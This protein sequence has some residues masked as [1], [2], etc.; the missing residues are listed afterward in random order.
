LLRRAT[1]QLAKQST[2]APDVFAD[3]L[4][5]APIDDAGGLGAVV[6]ERRLDGSVESGV[7]NPDRPGASP[8]FTRRRRFT[9]PK[10]GWDGVGIT[11]GD[12]Y[13]RLRIDL[14]Y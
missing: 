5:A 6:L 3:I 7:S 4:D 9:S 8:A 13:H 1:S 12:P 10:P 14:L 2:A 11:D